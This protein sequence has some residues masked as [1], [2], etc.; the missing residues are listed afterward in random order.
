MVETISS[1]ATKVTILT[2]LIALI[3]V[4]VYRRYIVIQKSI[5]EKDNLIADFL[6]IVVCAALVIINDIV[7]DH[8]IRLCL[9]AV[10]M[11][12][13]T[14]SVIVDWLKFVG[15]DTST[16][17]LSYVDKLI[18]HV[19]EDITKLKLPIIVYQVCFIVIK[20]VSFILAYIIL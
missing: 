9:S 12:I 7:Y 3:A 16:V 20:I 18:V 4:F 6:T 8:M 5:T 19:V 2:L 11:Y 1:I 10:L 15:R 17:M 14:Y 13:A